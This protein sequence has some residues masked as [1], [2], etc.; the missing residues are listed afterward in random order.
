MTNMLITPPSAEP[1]S[2]VEA[3]AH[4]RLDSTDEDDLVTALIVAARQVVEKHTGCALITQAWRVIADAWPDIGPLK[5]PLRPFISL[6]A[7]RVFDAGNAAATLSPATY[8]VDP[9][10]AA[11]RV[12]FAN[13]PPA[14]GRALAG[15]EIDMLIGYGPAALSVPEPLRLAI[16][17]LVAHWFEARGDAA[18]DASARQIPA[19][20]EAVL[21]PFRRLRLA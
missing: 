3:K 21:Q 1:L 13:A 20:I 16:R 9:Q 10:P 8:F 19:V 17:M 5:L 11:P 12:L 18:S 2:L 7:I 6:T 14:P 15:I 4:L